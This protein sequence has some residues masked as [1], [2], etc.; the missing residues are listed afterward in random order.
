MIIFDL[1]GTLALDEHRVHFLRETPKKW[2]A[3]FEACGND[4]LNWPIFNILRMFAEKGN[5]CVIWT[6]RSAEVQVTT[7][8]WL[9]R[10]GILD[11][12]DEFRMRAEGDHTDDHE[13]K[14]SW[15]HHAIA[16][17][18]HPYLVFEDRKR[19]VDMWREEGLICCQVAPGD[20]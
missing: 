8:Q 9:K 16:Q 5:R 3:Y 7:E 18:H 15:L 17:G 19:V 6:G 12:I 13:L 11:L 20:F 4:Q 10:Y 14:R 1:D 2:G